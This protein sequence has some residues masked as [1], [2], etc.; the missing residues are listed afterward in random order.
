MTNF[1][2]SDKNQAGE[3]PPV[4]FEHANLAALLQNP[5]NFVVF[6]IQLDPEEP[7]GGKVV[8]VSPSIREVTGIS[9]PYDFSSWFENI[10][11]EDQERARTANRQAIITG[12]PYNE[13]V[14]TFHPLKKAQVWL[15]TVSNPVFDSS[16]KLTHFNGL[17]VDVTEQK[18]AEEALQRQ[19]AFEYLL[20]HISTTFVNLEPDEIDKGIDQALQ[21][22]GEFARVDRCYLIHFSPDEGKMEVSHD[23]C[24]PDIPCVSGHLQNQWLESFPWMVRQIQKHSTVHIPDLNRFPQAAQVDKEECR[25]LGIQSLVWVPLIFKERAS[26]FIGFDTLHRPKEWSEDQISLLQIVGEIFTSALEQRKAQEA[27]RESQRRLEEQSEARTREVATLLDLSLNLAVTI[28]LEPKLDIILDQLKSVVDYTG[29]SIMQLDGSYL[30][31][32]AYRGPIP[33]EEAL[34]IRFALSQAGANQ[35]VIRR[36]HPVLIEDIRSDSPLAASFRKTAGDELNTTF[37]YMR[38]WL[39][40]PLIAGGQV[41]GMLS[42]D[43]PTPGYYKANP[44]SKLALAF[45]HQVAA[46]MENARLYAE[47][48]QRAEESQALFAVEQA[49]TSRLDRDIV[50]QMIADEARRLTNTSQG[51]VYLVDGDELRVA[52]VSGKADRALVGFRISIEESIAGIALKTGR[53]YLIH[54]AKRDKRVHAEMITRTGARSF[55]IVPLMSKNGPIG[56]ITVADKKDGPLTHEDERVLTLLASGAVIALENA[57]F[58]EEEQ[59]RRREADRR[60][61]VA[62]GLAHILRV[63]NSNKP[64]QETLDFIARQACILLEATSTMIRREEPDSE[65]VKT[66]AS[67]NLPREFDALRETRIYYR[68]DDRL[69]DSRRPLA[70]SDLNKLY[71]PLIEHPTPERDAERATFRIILNHFR[72]TLVV[73]LFFQEEIFGS[74]IFYFASTREFSE[75]DI[76]L[77]MTISDH[78]ALAIENARLRDQV[79]EKA[80]V[81]ERSRLAR[82]LHDAVTQTLFSAS[83]IAEVLPRLWERN[84]DEGL[85]RLEELRQLTRGALAE[86]RSLLLELR[87][88][89]L[90]EAELNELFKHL[91]DAF[92]G[93]TRIPMKVSF[94]GQI[95]LPAEV[96]IALYRIVQEALNNISKHAEAREVNLDVRCRPGEIRLSI[97]DN[98][99]GFDRAKV[100][101]EHL[102]L[103]IMKERAESIGA[104]LSISSKINKGTKILVV[105]KTGKQRIH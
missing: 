54:D 73:P 30:Q 87:P 3:I 85:R 53:A 13:V 88:T 18:L 4:N 6:Q 99:R 56:T 90:V 83:L 40:V 1:P 20:T 100:S 62:E 86:M 95:E 34:K 98:G 103:G 25:R 19:L 78:T 61:V 14:R 71:R 96:K 58:Y 10:H 55:V 32:V 27:L 84:Q 42:L 52:V 9:N 26:G 23:W 15:H 75:E 28:N 24:L 65:G 105:W 11:P 21:I 44:H 64:V 38:S 91:S 49:I 67:Y 7:F 50:L 93:R 39:G 92:V 66:V 81:T 29:A 101:S 2:A 47:A 8:L 5:H 74:L 35:E 46:A 60:R 102:G 68:A 51:A 48:R 94:E 97:S 77:A 70:L 12:E 41:Q 76:S 31:V 36:R 16:G 45:A 72:S 79:E 104:T 37:S 59:E 57:R 63:L 22:L 17:I 33:R 43:H 82:E 69:R 89:A 80:A